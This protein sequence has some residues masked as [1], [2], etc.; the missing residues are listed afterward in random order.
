[1]VRH[2]QICTGSG[3]KM[4]F[5]A[6]SQ[7]SETDPHTWWA[8]AE[9]HW[10]QAFPKGMACP[11]QQTIAQDMGGE[12]CTSALRQCQIHTWNNFDSWSFSADNRAVHTGHPCTVQRGPETQGLG[13]ITLQTSLPRSTGALGSYLSW[14]M[15]SWQQSDR[16]TE[17]Y[18]TN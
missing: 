13:W 15:L 10:N 7:S 1:M 5:T 12:R 14:T 9:P 16:G 17:C 6:D 8:T 11:Q 4:S 18:F 2:R 3:V